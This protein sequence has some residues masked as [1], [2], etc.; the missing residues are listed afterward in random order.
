[1]RICV[2]V[3]KEVK[4]KGGGEGRKKII[5]GIFFKKKSFDLDSIIIRSYNGTTILLV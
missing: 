4:K 5:R 1:M 3:K 2:E